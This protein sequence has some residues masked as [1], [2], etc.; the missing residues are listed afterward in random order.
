[1]LRRLTPSR[2]TMSRMLAGLE[3]FSKG[4]Y[5]FNRSS[6]RVGLFGVASKLLRCMRK[7]R[8]TR[9]G[10]SDGSVLVDSGAL[11]SESR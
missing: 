5:M 7:T 10:N 6:Q 9:K 11:G 4:K 8:G 3:Q 1:M 2:F